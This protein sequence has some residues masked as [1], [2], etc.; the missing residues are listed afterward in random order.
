MQI[1]AIE[2]YRDFLWYFVGGLTILAVAHLLTHNKRCGWLIDCVALSAF[3]VVLGNFGFSSLLWIFWIYLIGFVLLRRKSNFKI[4]KIILT[5]IIIFV[6]L[7][8]VVELPLRLSETYDSNPDI[9]LGVQFKPKYFVQLRNKSY[10]REAELLSKARKSSLGPKQEYYFVNKERIGMSGNLVALSDFKGSYIN[11]QGGHR[12][13]VGATGLRKNKV[14]VFGGSTIFCAEVPD[15]M[16]IPSELQKLLLKTR[17]DSDVFNYGIPGIRIE[18]QYDIL[19][20][21]DDFNFGD[22]VIFYDGVND[23]NVVFR[24][25]LE[26]HDSFVP[27]AELKALAG[28]LEK[29]SLLAQYLISGYVDREGVTKEF[30]TSEAEQHVLDLWIKNDKIAREYVESKGARFVHILQPNWV[31]FKGGIEATKDNKR[32]S[33][34]KVIQNYFEKYATPQMKIENFTRVLDGLSTT[35]YIDWAHLDEIGNKKVAEEMFKVLEPL[36]KEQS[37]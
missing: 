13:T 15:S 18:N 20:A 16:T 19:K 34:M 22:V 30:L 10:Y 37:K 9:Q 32:W 5:N 33:D 31:T 29:K 36:L 26:S 25:G 11:I 2:G 27:Y 12:V 4:F 23:L 8:S 35:P 14:L 28:M 17:F 3:F 7:L 21:V 24:N 1:Y 6:T